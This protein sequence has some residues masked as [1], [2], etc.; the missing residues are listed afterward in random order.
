MGLPRRVAPSAHAGVA[1]ELRPRRC[2]EIAE[3]VTF[4]G[5]TE[6]GRVRGSL[7]VMIVGAVLRTAR[8]IQIPSAFSVSRS[9]E[10]DFGKLKGRLCQTLS[11]DDFGT[12]LTSDPTPEAGA[13]SQPPARTLDD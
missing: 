11:R 10:L 12:S 3:P 2:A 4:A 1:W 13:L 8:R 5:P 9:P 6:V 7:G